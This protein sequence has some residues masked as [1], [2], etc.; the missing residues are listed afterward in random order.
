LAV[1]FSRAEIE[2]YSRQLVLPELGPEGQRKLKASS[3]IIIGAGGLGIPASVYL[4]AAGVGKIGIVDHDIVEKSNLHRQTIYTEADIG[5]PKA[6][7]AGDRLRLVNPH[8]LLIAHSVRLDS[9][10]ALEL[11]KGYDVVLDCTDNF[12]ARYL[13]NDASVLLG[14]PD[15]YS[16]VFRFDGQVSVFDAQRGP[17]YR[18]LFPQPP[19]PDTVQDCSVAGVLG[20]LPGIMGGLQAV[21]ATNLILG[22]GLP[23]IG[24]LVLFNATDMTFNELRVKKDPNC[25]VCGRAPTI[26][27]LIDYEEF[28]GIP[29]PAIPVKEVTPKELKRLMDG[30]EK[31]TL[32]DVRERPEY[33]ICKIEGSKLI[34]LGDLE[35][36]IGELKR[37]GQIVVYCQVGTRSARAV[38]LLSSKGIPALNLR[39]GIR[40]WAEQ[41]DPSMPVY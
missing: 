2:R 37:D 23:L 16:S 41:V 17:C 32:L 7:V 14:K 30:G 15:V 5:E 20:V 18:C 3:A 1:E 8:V 40:A 27:R 12:P 6:K 26:T 22:K 33:D 38:Q 39:G 29:K 34:P 31:V 13:I 21:Q 4:A 35:G 19:P 28:C 25:P 9:S 36:R 11:L 10:N 24:R